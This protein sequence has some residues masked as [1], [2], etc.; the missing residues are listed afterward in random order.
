MPYT[1]ESYEAAKAA[2]KEFNEEYPED[3]EIY[4]DAT[5][6][7]QRVVEPAMAYAQTRTVKFQ[8]LGGSFREFRY[9]TPEILAQEFAYP[10]I[11]D[12]IATAASQVG[13]IFLESMSDYY[14]LSISE[15][16]SRRVY[17]G[18]T[19]FLTHKRS[20]GE[21]DSEEITIKESDRFNCVEVKWTSHSLGDIAIFP[22]T[23]IATFEAMFRT[24]FP[25]MFKD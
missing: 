14:E 16:W 9:L 15:Q 12:R 18:V 3:T 1:Y 25:D 8:S 17:L 2:A 22:Y 23:D 21:I 6:P 11:N 20:D 4:L 19:F 13:G 10:E 5:G 24:M 7:A